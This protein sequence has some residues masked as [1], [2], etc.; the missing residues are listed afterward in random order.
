MKAE[1]W[2][3]ECIATVS[4]IAGGVHRD[5]ALSG[6]VTPFVVINQVAAS[7]VDNAFRD[8]IM[9]RE[10][11]RA[12]VV[13]ESISYAPVYPICEAIRNA[14]HKKQDDGIISATFERQHEQAEGD[15]ANPI[16]SII[17]EFELH[18]Q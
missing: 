7:P 18:T 15:A 9:D 5:V 2:L 1:T 10:V 4:G 16:K 6:T 13:H 3:R 8:N 14:L 11:W 17:M 12:K